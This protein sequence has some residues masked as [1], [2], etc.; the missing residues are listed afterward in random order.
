MQILHFFGKFRK[1]RKKFNF[2]AK[3]YKNIF[4]SFFSEKHCFSR[5]NTKKS[6]FFRLFSKK[7]FFVIFT[8]FCKNQQISTYFIEDG[9]Y[10]RIKNVQLTYTVPTSVLKKIKLSSMQIYVQGQNLLTLS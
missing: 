10:M 9:S 4:T 6:R 3:K 2:F 7:L 5:K 8:V 1:N